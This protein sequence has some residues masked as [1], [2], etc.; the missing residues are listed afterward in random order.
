MVMVKLNDIIPL[1]YFSYLKSLNTCYYTFS[2]RAMPP[3]QVYL[4]AL[5]ISTM[6]FQYL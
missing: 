1:E 3:I 6:I 2:G 5:T 4:I